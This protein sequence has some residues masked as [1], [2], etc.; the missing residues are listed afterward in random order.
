[1]IFELVLA[2]FLVGGALLIFIAAVGLLRMPDLFT[3]MSCS[4]KASTLGIGLLLLALAL[5]FGQ[6]G[7]T[8]RALATIAFIV[9]TTPVASHR[10]GRVAYLGGVPLWQ[11]TFLDE[12]GAAAFAPPTQQAE[13][14]FTDDN[15][16]GGG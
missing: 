13:I 9:L 14:M 7:V 4:A 3:R 16:P 15:R 12:W 11:E 5:Y 8:S 1:M 2:A 6:L 10:I